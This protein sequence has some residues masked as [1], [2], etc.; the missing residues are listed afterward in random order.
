M[1]QIKTQIDLSLSHYPQTGCVI[2]LIEKFFIVPV[3]LFVTMILDSGKLVVD[4]ASEDLNIP[5]K[6]ETS[7]FYLLI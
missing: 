6:V 5:Q 3:V 7:H 4:Q 2:S 1:R